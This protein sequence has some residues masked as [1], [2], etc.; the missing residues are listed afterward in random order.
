MQFLRKRQLRPSVRL[1]GPGYLLCLSLVLLL[2]KH[3]LLKVTY[4]LINTRRNVWRAHISWWFSVLHLGRRKASN[5]VSPFGLHNQTEYTSPPVPY[6]RMPCN[7][8]WGLC[9]RH[10]SLATQRN[11]CL[12]RSQSCPRGGTGNHITCPAV[13]GFFLNVS[14]QDFQEASPGQL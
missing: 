11:A 14:S 13:L 8:S 12:N 6:E 1:D 3:K 7:K 4:I 2:C 5:G 10:N 9:S